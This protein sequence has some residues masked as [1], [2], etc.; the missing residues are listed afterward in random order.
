MFFNE[1]KLE[2]LRLDN[3]DIIIILPQIDV[4]NLIANNLPYINS[5]SKF[6]N[7]FNAYQLSISENLTP[8]K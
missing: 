6:L 1:F 2:Y 5:M 4:E 7:E 8:K 3:N